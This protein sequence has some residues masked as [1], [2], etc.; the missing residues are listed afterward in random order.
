MKNMHIKKLAITIAISLGLVFIFAFFWTLFSQPYKNRNRWLQRQEEKN[1]QANVFYVGDTATPIKSG[2]AA[3]SKEEKENYKKAVENQFSPFVQ[4]CNLWAPY[5]RQA[6]SEGSN[7]KN[8]AELK[9]AY[10]DIK[11]AFSYYLSTEH[12]KEPLILVGEGQGGAYVLRLLEDFFKK[13]RYKN[14][15]VCAYVWN[16]EIPEKFKNNKE[17]IPLSTSRSQNRVLVTEKEEIETR[18]ATFYRGGITS[19]GEFVEAL[20]G[21]E[22]ASARDGVITLKKD[23]KISRPIVIADGTYTILGKGHTITRDCN[24]D[25]FAITGD[26][27]SRMPVLNLGDKSGKDSLIIDGAADSFGKTK[28]A[29]FAVY[30]RGTL[31]F[32]KGS[33][34]KNND[35]Q[36][37]DGG[38]VYGECSYQKKEDGNY[39]CLEPRISV[40]GAEFT[41]NKTE[42]SGGAIAVNGTKS[43]SENRVFGQIALFS[44]TFTGNSAQKS[45]NQIYTHTAT[46]AYSPSITFEEGDVL[47]E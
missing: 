27:A 16:Y 31:N 12:G 4:Y 23:I 1:K 26:D 30:G 36:S 32:Y 13:D 10:K 44:G 17:N 19:Q 35:R 21:L 15:L 46:L 43:A 20:G 34:L 5:Y 8:K 18:L 9:K 6:S 28:G 25:L 38:A 7:K 11:K 47:Q 33:L 3:L 45:G 37:Y 29:L 42:E 24:E 41:N 39:I 14:R 22:Y 40:F 2:N